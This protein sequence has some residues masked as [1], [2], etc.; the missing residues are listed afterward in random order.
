MSKKDKARRRGAPG[1]ASTGPGRISEV[2]AAP[3]VDPKVQRQANEVAERSLASLWESVASGDLLRAELEI[4][5]CMAFPYVL[6]EREP[7]EIEKWYDAALVRGA[8][9]R[10][11]PD[12]AALL[13]LLMTLGPPA[14]RRAASRALA[15]LTGEGIYPPDWVTELGKVTPGQAWRRYDV[16]GDD[17][18]IAVTFGYAGASTASVVQ[19]DLTGIPVAA[20][21]GVYSDAARL[22]EVISGSTEEFDRAEQISLAEARDRMLLP[23]DRKAVTTAP[24]WTRAASQSSAPGPV[25]GAPPPGR[26]RRALRLSRGLR[27]VSRGIRGV[28]RGIRARP[29]T[30]RRKTGPPR[31]RTS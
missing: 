16:F 6:G 30:T 25:P 13:R 19:V 26:G 5:T 15:E 31:S 22:I 29:R 4:S 17:E 28:S 14:T 3:G 23:L 27:G 10:G 9:R 2:S 11:T 7:A 12:G 18:G 20:A 1:L 24:S 8:V 21:I